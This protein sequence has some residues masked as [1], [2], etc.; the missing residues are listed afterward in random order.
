[1]YCNFP[2]LFP[3]YSEWGRY[4]FSVS[5]ITWRWHFQAFR[6]FEVKYSISGDQPYC[7]PLVCHSSEVIP[8]GSL[9]WKVFLA[10]SLVLSF[11]KIKLHYLSE[12]SQFNYNFLATLL[13]ISNSRIFRFLCNSLHILQT[14]CNYSAI[15]L[16]FVE[17]LWSERNRTIKE[18]YRWCHKADDKLSLTDKPLRIISKILSYFV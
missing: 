15:I 4:Y 1:M 12:I 9:K 7:G 17:V 14:T 6:P 18:T 2:N 5:E 11:A 16:S 8:N 3:I 13:S 10:N